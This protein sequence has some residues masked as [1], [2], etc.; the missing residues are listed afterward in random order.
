MVKNVVSFILSFVILMAKMWIFGFSPGC[1]RRDRMI[2]CPSLSAQC[3]MEDEHSWEA[4]DQAVLPQVV[5]ERKWGN[6]ASKTFSK[7]KFDNKFFSKRIG[8]LLAKL[9]KQPYYYGYVSRIDGT[10]LTQVGLINFFY[11]YADSSI[12]RQYR[13]VTERERCAKNLRTVALYIGNS[14]RTYRMCIHAYLVCALL[15]RTAC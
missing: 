12:V 13:L 10:L 2:W 14:E 4:L 8:R 5:L 15:Y 9:Y 7:I 1:A 6:K 11:R 3:L